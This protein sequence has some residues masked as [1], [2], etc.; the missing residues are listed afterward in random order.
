[1]TELLRSGVVGPRRAHFQVG[2]ISRVPKERRNSP[3]GAPEGLGRDRLGSRGSHVPARGDRLKIIAT[4][5]VSGHPVAPI[6]LRLPPDPVRSPITR[7]K[8]QIG[9]CPGARSIGLPRS[10]NFTL[11]PRSP[12]R[13]RR[14]PLLAT[15]RLRRN[16]LRCR[17]S[18]A[19]IDLRSQSTPH[20]A[21][22]GDLEFS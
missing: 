2:P 3:L 9:R 20:R 17:P 6:T 14:S 8:A 10:R 1:M 19:R 16:P 12:R 5:T 13:A 15:R 22:Y 4:L 21:R 7:R 18:R 11:V